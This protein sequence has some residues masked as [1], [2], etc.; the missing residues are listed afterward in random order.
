MPTR[1]LLTVVNVSSNQIFGYVCNVAILDAE[2]N[3][4]MELEVTTTELSIMRRP[5]TVST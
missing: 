3:I 5:A 4:L 1:V 2:E